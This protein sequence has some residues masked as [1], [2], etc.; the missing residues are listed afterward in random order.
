MVLAAAASLAAYASP[1]RA[2]ETLKFLTPWT[3]A[4]ESNK[5]TADWVV[6]AVKKL[7][8]GELEARWFG[9]AVVPPFQQLQP[10]SS[11]AFDLHYTSPAYHNGATVVGGLLDAVARE[12]S[13]RRSSGV[14]DM[15]DQHYS[16]KHNAK[17]LAVAG[18]TSYQ[19]VLKSPIGPDGGLKGL[20]IRSTP[21]YDELIAHLGGIS[22]Q[23][24]PPQM[25]TSL[26]KN[27]IDGVA[28]PVHSIVSLKLHEVAKYLARPTFGTSTNILIMNY[29]KWKKLSPKHQQIML[30]VGKG[31]EQA[32]YDIPKEIADRDEKTMLSTGSKVVQLAPNYAKDIHRIFA[33][34]L[35]N[36]GIKLQAA[37]AKPIVDMIKAK[38]IMYTG[39]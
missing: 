1:V 28:F 37:D 33:D 36:R 22:T 35:W 25:Y 24:A 19:F 18:S 7:S 5:K 17:V 13:K 12:Q 20:K 16:T 38:G 8:G 4:Q 6:E 23:L 29:D 26:Q 14:W 27:L 39:D 32:A 2:A 11:G 3:T 30:E 21:A 10:V 34:G 9:P 15:V 31:F